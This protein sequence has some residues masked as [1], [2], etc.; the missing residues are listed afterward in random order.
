MM[1]HAVGQDRLTVAAIIIN[2]NGA[3]DTLALLNSLRGCQS[4]VISVSVVVIDNGSRPD[5][6]STLR[7]GIDAQGDGLAITLRSNATNIG[8][9]GAYNQAIQLA[10]LHHDYYLRLDNDVVVEPH[11]LAHM[12]EALKQRASEGVAIV[13][14]NIKY[15]DRPSNDNG[16]AVT[17]DLVG[18]KN[19]IDYPA[20]DTV[21][22]G[23]LGCVMLVSGHLVRAFAPNVF[24]TAL[25]LS[26]DESELSLRA[27]REGQRTLYLSQVVGFH[28]SG[29]STGKVPVLTN[30]YAARNWTLLRLRYA[31]GA[32][33]RLRILAGIPVDLMRHIARGRWSCV[34]GVMAGVALGLVWR[35]DQTV[36]LRHR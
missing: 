7:G 6:L 22:D 4:D 15:F 32:C 12:V 9:P 26:A 28:R 23:V 13:G 20:T 17:F 3:T 16:G 24:D 30:Y 36:R 25:F 29:H 33:Q 18:G 35:L 5:D 27:G 2:W 19:S 14:G 10:G 1:L 8:V 21:C 31:S 11:G 34:S